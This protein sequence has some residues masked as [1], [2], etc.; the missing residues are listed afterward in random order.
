MKIY[1]VA[2]EQMRLLKQ[3]PLERR[4]TSIVKHDGG[5]VMSWAHFATIRRQSLPHTESDM[6]SSVPPKQSRVKCEVIGPKAELG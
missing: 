4:L 3:H 1:K 6:K 5:E 2:S